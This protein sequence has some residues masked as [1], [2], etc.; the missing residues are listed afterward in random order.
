MLAIFLSL[1]GHIVRT[2]SD[3]AEALTLASEF[4]PNVVCTDIVMPGMNGIELRHRLSEQPATSA[5]VVFATTAL[6]LEERRRLQ[7]VGFDRVFGKPLDLEALS[8]SV[9]EIGRCLEVPFLT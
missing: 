1:Q 6:P 3:G 7:R 5:I 8:A 9:R 2:A 4:R